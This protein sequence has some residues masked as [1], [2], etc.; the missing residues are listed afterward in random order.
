[1][2]DFSKSLRV[3]NACKTENATDYYGI[4]RYKKGSNQGAIGK[5]EYAGKVT[6]IAVTEASSK[7]FKTLSGA[8]KYMEQM[9]YK[10][11]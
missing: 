3:G 4:V 8:K 7:S 6:Y 1:M 2:R 11:V 5:N 9:G 10:E